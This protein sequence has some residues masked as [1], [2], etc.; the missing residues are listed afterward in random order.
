MV[1]VS[2]VVESSSSEVVMLE[3]ESST[4][5]S[6]VVIL[7]AESS[8]TP[9]IVVMLGSGVVVFGLTF[10]FDLNFVLLDLLVC[11]EIDLPDCFDECVVN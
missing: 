3:A 10:A 5:L 8:S 7:E 6:T 4:S 1:V 11:F 2:I 9:A